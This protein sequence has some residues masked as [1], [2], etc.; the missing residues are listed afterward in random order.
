MIGRIQRKKIQAHL[1]ATVSQNSAEVICPLCNRTVPPSQQDARHLVPKS[2]G[3]VET[4]LLHRICHRQ[5]HALF[6]EFELARH[7]NT[8]EALKA[9]TEMARFIEWVQTK[10]DSFYEKTK[11]SQRLQ[12]KST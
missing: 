8:T 7:Y 6:K 10:P 12:H 1:E 9:Q 2:H 5:V 3:G 11:K 4:I